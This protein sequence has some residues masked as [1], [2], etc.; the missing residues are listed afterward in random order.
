M[1]IVRVRIEVPHAADEVRFAYEL[2]GWLQAEGAGIATMAGVPEDEI[3]I[4][5]AY[6]VKRPTQSGL[7]MKSVWEYIGGRKETQGNR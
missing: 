7:R 5:T 2:A 1:A 6:R 4:R 3:A